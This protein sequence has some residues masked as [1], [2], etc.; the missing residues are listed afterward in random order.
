MT[1]RFTL[2]ALVVFFIAPF[3][4][5]AQQQPIRVNCGGPNYTDA[6]G[7]LW[8]ADYGYNEGAVR[9]F[10]AVIKG[11]SSQALFQNAR[12]Y[13]GSGMAYHF[14]V[15]D[16]TY[17]VN[18]YFAETNAATQ[19]VGGRVFN[20]KMQGATVFSRLDVFAEAGADAALVKGAD[21]VVSQGSIAIEFDAVANAPEVNAIEILPGA[22]GPQLSLSFKY[23]DGTPVVGTLSYA[24]TSSLLS[25][26]GQQPLVNGQA[27]CAILANPS[28]LGLSMQFTL[29]VSLNDSAGHLL[30]NMNVL[31]NPA[32]V[33]LAAVQNSTLTV[34]V[35]KITTQTSG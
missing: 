29:K 22:S 11:T 5:R 13:V 18:L 35:Q 15:P 16:G 6:S 21:I 26:S 30:W 17:H 14:P 8:K 4:A 1:K 28:D 25:F 7:N 3:A 19:I 27:T 33:N 32:E 9:S 2:L 10:S 12:Y 31:L 23:P 20:V 24:V 34:T